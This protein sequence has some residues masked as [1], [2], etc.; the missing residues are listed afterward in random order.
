MSKMAMDA[1]DPPKDI[2]SPAYGFP[3]RI[4]SWRGKESLIRKEWVERFETLC[5]HVDE[6]I[7]EVGQIGKTEAEVEP[8]NALS[9]EREED[10]FGI[11]VGWRNNDIFHDV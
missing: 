8:Q 1:G 7:R 10:N 5:S 4:V 3:S 9:M 11:D 6:R 2:A